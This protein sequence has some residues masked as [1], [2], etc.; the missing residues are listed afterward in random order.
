MNEGFT[1]PF[2]A[3]RRV[4]QVFSFEEQRSTGIYGFTR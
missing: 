3:R 4:G 2:S 1:G